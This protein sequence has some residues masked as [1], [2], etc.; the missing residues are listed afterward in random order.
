MKYL[1]NIKNGN[2]DKFD[3][4]TNKSSKFFF[5]HFN[6]YLRQI[7]EQVKLVRHSVITNNETALEILQNKDWQYFIER[8]LEAC[9]LKINGESLEISSAKE[10]KIIQDSVE[11][12]TICKTL[13]GNYYNQV[14]VGLSE[15][16][17]N[18]LLEE[19]IEIDKHL[20]IFITNIMMRK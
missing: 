19:L 14:G 13:Y 10:V 20:L 5:Y 6:N 1:I 16:L 3:M 2:D 12:F 9:Q 17:R 8:I 11:N 15:T 18:L 4:L 7:N